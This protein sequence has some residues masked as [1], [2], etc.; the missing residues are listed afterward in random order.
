MK[1]NIATYPKVKTLVYCFFST[2]PTGEQSYKIKWDWM[3]FISPPWFIRCFWGLLGVSEVLFPAI[4]RFRVRLFWVKMISG[5]H[6]H[7]NPYVW[8]QWKIK[9]SGNHLPVD[10]N[11]C[12]W[13]GNE[14]TSSFSLQFIFGKRE[15]ERE[16]REPRSEREREEEEISLAIAPLVNR[17]ARSSDDRTARRTIALRRSSDERRDRRLPALSSRSSDDH[18]PRRSPALSSSSLSLR[19]GLS[20]LSLSLSL[21]LFFRK[22]FELK[23]RV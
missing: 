21:S 12:L 9:F 19:S 1:I 17:R 6:F 13:P 10:E 4:A 20:P 7:P 11:L 5:N 18:A 2:A 8:L 3:I 15:R 23:I 16:K 22:W 14:F